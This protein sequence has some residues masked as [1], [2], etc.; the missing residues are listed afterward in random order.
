LDVGLVP[1]RWDA[2]PQTF[3]WMT[4]G[5]LNWQPED[6]S[7]IVCG[8]SLAEQLLRDAHGQIER[9]GPAIVMN[10]AKMNLLS[11][12]QTLAMLATAALGRSDAGRAFEGSAFDSARRGG[13]CRIACASQKELGD[14]PN[15]FRAG[16]ELRRSPCAQCLLRCPSDHTLIAPRIAIIWPIR[17]GRRFWESIGFANRLATERQHA[18]VLTCEVAKAD[19]IADRRPQRA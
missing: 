18:M 9:L 12:V 6:S 3:V 17:P 5:L 4:R 13:K 10:L 1:I 15:Q 11:R 7:E 14:I 16:R 2:S 19:V 8:R